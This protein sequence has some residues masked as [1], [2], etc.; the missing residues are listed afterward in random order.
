MQY[1]WIHDTLT[2][3]EE[4]GVSF[5]DRGYYF[6]DGIYEVIR[7]YDGKPFLWEEHFER[8]TRSAAELD[9]PFPKPLENIKEDMLH[10]IETN[11]VHNGII[12]MQMTRGVQERNHLYSREITPVI[13]AFTKEEDVPSH[14]QEQ[15]ISLRAVEDIRWLRCDIKTI[16]LLG[17]VMA[18]RSAEDNGCHEALLHR[19]PTVTEG[20]STNVFMVKN[21]VIYTHPADNYILKGIT[22]QFIQKLC[23]EKGI[24][25]K[26]S[27][28][29]LED[30]RG[31]DELF[32]ASTSHE[33]VPV[34]RVSGTI[35][36]TLPSRELTDELQKT[37]QERK[38]S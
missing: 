17:N 1:V 4:A 35:E 20:S 3:Q 14:L 23:I 22:R 31:A 11:K 33:I 26:E 28:F 8:F 34:H 37:F 36:K 38:L 2:P 24:P 16:N 5:E 21:G 7:L 30:L 10:L 9:L 32:I 6:G 15:G 12:Y 29:T 13:T 19:G 18:K 25:F 27:A